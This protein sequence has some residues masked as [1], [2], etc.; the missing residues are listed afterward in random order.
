MALYNH[1]DLQNIIEKGIL[2][3]H[4]IKELHA[5][6]T[7]NPAGIATYCG[8][9]GTFYEAHGTRCPNPTCPIPLPKPSSPSELWFVLLNMVA[10][11]LY[12]IFT[13]DALLT[14]IVTFILI[15]TSLVI[16]FFM[17]VI[18]NTI[19]RKFFPTKQRDKNHV[20]LQNVF[21][22][23][24]PPAFAMLLI[25]IWLGQFPNL[26]WWIIEFAVGYLFNLY[27]SGRL[28]FDTNTYASYVSNE[29]RGAAGAGN[30]GSSRSNSKMRIWNY[31]L[32]SVPLAFMVI[33]GVLFVFGFPLLDML[34]E[35]LC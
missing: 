35:L 7:S 10:A 12:G 1:R 26:S 19:N 2:D 6:T 11:F 34:C 9:C 4:P 18:L 31:P 29:N 20:W 16:F 8:E 5:R 23:I 32:V 3:T 27:A 21:L 22:T 28:Q 30:I 15:T 24:V 33:L 17:I 25:A 14:L 13:N